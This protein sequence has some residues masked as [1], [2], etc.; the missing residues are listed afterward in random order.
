[1]DASF[2]GDSHDT[3][4]DLVRHRRP[5]LRCFLTAAA[6]MARTCVITLDCTHWPLHLGGRGVIRSGRHLTAAALSSRS[7][8]IRIVFSLLMSP[9]L[10]CW[11]GPTVVRKKVARVPLGRGLSVRY[12]IF[13][14]SIFNKS[15]PSWGWI[16]EWKQ[17]D[18]TPCILKSFIFRSLLSKTI[19][20]F[21]LFIPKTVRTFKQD[22]THNLQINFH[23]YRYN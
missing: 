23:C 10:V 4:G 14:S 11:I 17:I 18:L 12:P 3:I 6:L 22:L 15:D 9:S 16:R 20:F 7:D 13:N 21:Y 2:H 19:T 5:E 1:M 8:V